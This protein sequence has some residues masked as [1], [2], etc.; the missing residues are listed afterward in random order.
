MRWLYTP[1]LILAVVVTFT[2][3]T[4]RVFA[5][6]NPTRIGTDVGALFASSDPWTQAITVSSTG[7]NRVLIVFVG[8]SGASGEPTGITALKG[9]SATAMTRIIN[10]T[11]AQQSDGSMWFLD[12]PDTGSNSIVVTWGSAQRGFVI[13][14]VYQD[15]L[16][17][18]ASVVDTSAQTNDGGTSISQNIT[19]SSDGDIVIAWGAFFKLVTNL[20]ANGSQATIATQLGG[21]SDNWFTATDVAQASHGTI[22]TG[23]T[24][25]TN[26]SEDLYTAALKFQAPSASGPA[27]NNGDN[28]L[29]LF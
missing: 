4:P 18:S 16:Q 27:Y 5:A 13:G 28:W 20:T 7:Q 11:A 19:T 24:W 22:S 17:S 15:M 14:T 6:T 1:L 21:S 2:L 23:F 9:G 3:K 29:L 10:F 25:T 12:N 26:G 8:R